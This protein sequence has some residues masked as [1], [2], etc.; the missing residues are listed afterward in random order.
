MVIFLTRFTG[1]SISDKTE[2]I[3]K[4]GISIIV[5]ALNG[6]IKKL[7]LTPSYLLYFYIFAVIFAIKQ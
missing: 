5:L 3:E 2:E 1:P 6:S 7:L 4:K